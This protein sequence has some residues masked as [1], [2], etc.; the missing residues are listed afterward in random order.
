MEPGLPTHP[1]SL[2]M[3]YNFGKLELFH[4]DIPKLLMDSFKYGS[5]TSPF[6]KSAG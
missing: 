1:C 4:L 6:E 3:L 2:T 5:W